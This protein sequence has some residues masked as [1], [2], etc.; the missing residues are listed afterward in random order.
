VY[1]NRVKNYSR[2]YSRVAALAVL[3]FAAGC[4]RAETSVAAQAETSVAA[5]AETSQSAKNAGSPIFVWS[6]SSDTHGFLRVEIWGVGKANELVIKSTS[7][8]GLV[9]HRGILT[10]LPPE[11]CTPLTAQVFARSDV[12]A[13][14]YYKFVPISAAIADD[15]SLRLYSINGPAFSKAIVLRPAN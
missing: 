11:L 12:E 4:A 2:F 8:P 5:K 9:R 15:G 13:E 6:G 3:V 14:I 10:S 7:L 1:Q